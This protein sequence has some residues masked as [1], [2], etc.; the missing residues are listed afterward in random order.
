[1]V[2]GS[3]SVIQTR[4]MAGEHAVVL[5]VFYTLGL[6]AMTAIPAALVWVTP[7]T[8]DIP[9]FL[10]IGLLAQ[11]GQFCFLRSHQLAETNVL[12]PLSYLAIVF[13]TLADYLYFGI[14]PTL[15]LILGSVVIIGSALIGAQV[16]YRR[17][18]P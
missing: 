9:A 8:S 12:A 1:V 14:T 15:S 4:R 18:G 10:I 11:L 3:L 7:R 16:G 6:A 2:V 5:M 17:R 13:S